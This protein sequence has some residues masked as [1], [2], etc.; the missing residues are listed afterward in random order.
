MKYAGRHVQ[1]AYKANIGGFS[2]EFEGYNKIGVNTFFTGKMGRCSYIGSN[3]N[4]NA[5]VGRYCSIAP[6]VKVVAGSHPTRDWV[7]TSPVFFSTLL[8]CG[9]SYVDK[10]LF[11][12]MPKPTNIGNDV[13]IGYGAVLLNGITI[14]NGAIV[15]AGSVVV[16]DVP[17]YAIVGGVP[18]KVIRYRF[19]KDQ[20]ERLEKLKWWDKGDDWIREHSTM[21]NDVESFLEDIE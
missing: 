1:I 8:Q 12:E 13:W 21:F 5:S 11:D 19:N 2:T 15:A 16:N 3:C 10:T 9:V 18:A 6:N 14:A 7:S 4:V 20:I 17:P